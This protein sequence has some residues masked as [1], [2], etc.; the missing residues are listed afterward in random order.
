MQKIRIL[1]IINRVN[2]GGPMHNVSILSKFLSDQ[3]ETLL[4]GG[5]IESHEASGMY[6]LDSMGV[7]FHLIKNMYRS[8]HPYK[9]F[10]ALIEIIK[11]V[12]D[13]KPDIIHTHAAKAGALGRFAG[14]ISTHKPKAIFHTYHGNIFDGYFSKFKTFIFL[15]IERFLAKRTTMLIAISNLQK[16]DLVNTYK[17]ST[18]NKVAVIPLG[19]DLKYLQQNMNAKREIFRNEFGLSSS[20]V[21]ISIIGRLTAIKN[22]EFL[23]KSFAKLLSCTSESIKLFIVG[24]GELR[25][26]LELAALQLGLEYYRNDYQVLNPAI[27]FLSWRKDI[28]Y[29]NAGSD[30]VALCSLNEG[31]PVS[32]IEAMAAG[33]PIVTTRVG[34]VEDF[35]TNGINGLIVNLDEQEFSNALLSLI[36]D[37]HLSNRVSENAINSVIK[38]FDYTRLIFDINRLYNN[39]LM[40]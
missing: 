36:R 39:H 26:Y 37:K 31:T 1:R 12:N 2:V 29:V 23:L 21:V 30:I 27:Y 15:T 33:K 18:N 40:N 25:E 24:D 4:I 14:I 22:H 17:I 34:G 7:S 19:F 38:Q 20:D 5:N 28:D 3:Y 11:I 9:D 8:I 10:L 13:F 6:L 32:I 16:D 35:I